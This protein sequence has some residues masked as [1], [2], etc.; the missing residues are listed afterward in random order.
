VRP[1]DNFRRQHKDLVDVAAEI[2]ASLA[3][4]QLVDGTPMR[5]LLGRFA[6]RLMMHAAMEEEA[7]YP[8]LMVHEREDVRV[9]ATK[10]HG[11]L[12]GIYTDVGDFVQKWRA[13]GAIEAAPL[14]FVGELKRVFAMLRNRLE[15]E[16]TLLYPVADA[17]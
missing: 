11:E 13:S 15:Q 5:R 6:G 9:V 16:E 2:E 10:L 12:S 17:L 8:R 7:L 4:Q 3:P 1:T 14:V